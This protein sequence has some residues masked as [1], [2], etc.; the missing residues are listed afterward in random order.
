MPVWNKGFIAN[1]PSVSCTAAQAQR[2]ANLGQL[3]ASVAEINSVCDDLTATAVEIT[4]KCDGNNSYVSTGTGTSYTV[5]A[6]S[7]GKIHTMGAIASNQTITLP[8]AAD[9]LNYKFIYI[10]GADEAQNFI[11]ASPAAAAYFRGGVM[12][13]D[14]DAETVAT[15]YSDGDSNDNFTMIKPGAGTIVNLLCDGTVWYIWGIVCSVTVP[16]FAD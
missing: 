13:S 7:T 6:A 15:V 16:T 11:I 8:A 14:T 12:H 9:G 3:T 10:G 4:N 5:L 1:E 2:L